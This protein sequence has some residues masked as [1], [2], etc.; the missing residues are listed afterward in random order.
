[1]TQ[2]AV[3]TIAIEPNKFLLIV[4]TILKNVAV[5]AKQQIPNSSH[6]LL[7]KTINEL[8]LTNRKTKF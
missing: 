1:V 2:I 6:Q 4:V 3:M 7:A 5:T 8:F